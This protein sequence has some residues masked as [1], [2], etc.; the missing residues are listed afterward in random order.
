MNLLDVQ[1]EL[2][3]MTLY[4]GD[5]D[6][7]YVPKTGGAVEALLATHHVAGY[8][9]WPN[10]RQLIAAQQVLAKLRGI[11]VGGIDGRVGP[12]SLHAFEI[13][14]ARKANGWK[15][16]ADLEAWRDTP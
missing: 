5:L 8:A 3:A 16:V 6:N 15:P 14:D 4:A 2:Q 13:Y 12:L 10:S 7:N 1:L 11:E 9:G